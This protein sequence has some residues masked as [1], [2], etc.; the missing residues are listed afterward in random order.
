M[1]LEQDG[2]DDEKELKPDYA[3][4]SGYFVGFIPTLPTLVMIQDLLSIRW[5]GPL[6][7]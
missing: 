4:W 5:L 6:E 2:P 1:G 7:R 3:G